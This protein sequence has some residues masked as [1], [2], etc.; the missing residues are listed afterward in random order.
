MAF[1]R[2]VRVRIGSIEVDSTDSLESLRVAFNVKRDKSR[3]PDSAE[4]VLYNLS[5]NTRSSLDGKERLLARIEAGYRD[6]GVKQIFFGYLH[7]VVHEKDDTEWVT[8]ISIADDGKDKRSKVVRVNRSFAKNTSVGQV[9]KTLVK[10]TGIPE[11][12][13]AQFAAVA[14][15]RGSPLLPRAWNAAGQALEEL[16][17]FCRSMGW[18][19]SIK[20][21]AFQFLEIGAPLLGTGPLIY[22]ASG[23]IGSPSVDADG[24]ISVVS[25]ML[26][27][28]RPGQAF[29][30]QSDVNGSG[31]YFATAVE[32]MGDTH[33]KDW[34]A[35]I[36]GQPLKPGFKPP[37]EIVIN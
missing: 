9:L 32:H 15:L 13:L 2:A 12:N 10:A 35:K 30:V 3:D 11:G 18:E 21:G 33:G 8:R 20:E 27:D 6:E 22:K 16:N 36:E 17:G 23:M 25:L 19:F 29:V 31:Q 14:R 28:I 1:G 5:A 26:P 34:Y 24:N 4:L 7:D 37:S